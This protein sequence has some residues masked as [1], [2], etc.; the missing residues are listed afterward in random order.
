MCIECIIYI[1]IY[2]KMIDIVHF[3]LRNRTNN[4][5]NFQQFGTVLKISI[6][7]LFFLLSLCNFLNKR[8][9]FLKIRV[10]FFVD[11]YQIFF[12]IILNLKLCFE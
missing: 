9:V 11:I 1:F 2:E 10:F 5:V 6:K 4:L 12:K 8:K 3:L 7:K